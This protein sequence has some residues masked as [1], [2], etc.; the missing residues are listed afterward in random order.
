MFKFVMTK[1]SY[2]LFYRAVTNNDISRTK[3]ILDEALKDPRFNIDE[4]NDDGLTALQS[5]CFA[6][7]LDIVKMLVSKQAN[8][9]IQDREGNTL[10]HAA[11]MMG[12]VEVVKYLLSLGIKP[13]V[14]ADNGLMPIDTTDN[15][16]VIVVLL[17]AMLDQ[18]YLYEM[19][20]YMLDHPMLKRKIFQE[21]E[22]VKCKENEKKEILKDLPYTSHTVKRS[23]THIE[24]AQGN[25]E[26]TQR[27]NR[28]LNTFT[29]YTESSNS[30]N[31]I[32]Q[33]HYSKLHANLLESHLSRQNSLNSLSSKSS[34]SSHNS[35]GGI[36][37]NT[38]NNMDT[39]SFTQQYLESRFPPASKSVSF[40]PDL[41]TSKD[42]SK[43]RC[44]STSFENL[45]EFRETEEI[46][47]ESIYENVL[48]KPL[49]LPPIL[50]SCLNKQVDDSP[51]P[52]LPPREPTIFEPPSS[53]I[54]SKR[55]KYFDE[56]S[57]YHDKQF[58][59]ET[60]SGI[61]I[62]ETQ[63][64]LFALSLEDKIL[65]RSSESLDNISERRETF[66]Q[67]IGLF[68]S[69]DKQTTIV[70]QQVSSDDNL[71]CGFFIRTHLK[72]N[73]K[74]MSWN[75]R[76]LQKELDELQ[77]WYNSYVK[78]RHGCS[79][80][81]N[82]STKYVNESNK[83]DFNNKNAKIDKEANNYSIKERVRA[84]S[85]GNIYNSN[86]VFLY[87]IDHHPDIML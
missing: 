83:N 33:T 36:L 70:K 3:L 68:Y 65:S 32:E 21:L 13:V 63:G 38:D 46:V 15:I 41:I 31:L 26:N 71:P 39:H 48:R 57:Q 60:D 66:S 14:K 85:T 44:L 19:Q 82:F 77:P 20:D 76:S 22:V 4:I 17:R 87:N 59:S 27:M 1:N 47:D 86:D 67:P 74:H 9:K 28:S 73:P 30:I 25:A 84:M 42:L 75:G 53:D 12:R 18:G 29:S 64:R 37:K 7:N 80:D 11:A 56:I 23:L 6:G 52:P 49:A 5:S 35:V 55:N 51:P 79:T 78:D 61:D 81:T 2:E 40:E 58:G 16:S 43:S 34:R 69:R 8:W 24:K 54:Y 62:N 10:L 50:E 72:T 45:N